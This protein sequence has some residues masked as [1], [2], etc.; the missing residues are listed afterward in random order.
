M[1]QISQFIRGI[2]AGDLII[3]AFCLVLIIDMTA[4][5]ICSVSKLTPNPDVLA[6]AKELTIAVV[7]AMCTFLVKGSNPPPPPPPAVPA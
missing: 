7:S 4:L 3:A 1:N 6:N 5:A 2:R